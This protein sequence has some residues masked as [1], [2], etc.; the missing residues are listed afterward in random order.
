MIKYSLRAL[1]GLAF[2]LR[3][4]NDIDVYV[5]D[6]KNRNLYEVLINRILNGKARVTS[7]VQLGGRAAVIAACANDQNDSTRR[8]IYLADGDYDLI[9][10][11]AA[12][13]LRYFYRLNVY[14]LEN[15]IITEDAVLEVAFENLIDH[16]KE[17]AKNLIEFQTFI[18]NLKETLL[19]LFA[20]YGVVHRIASAHNMQLHI[21]T[22]A[23]PVFKL[24]VQVAKEPSIE[25]QKVIDRMEEILDTLANDYGLNRVDVETAVKETLNRIE[26]STKDFID[27]ISA[28]SYVLPLLY[29]RLRSRAHYSGSIEQL[30]VHLA[31]HVNLHVDPGFYQAIVETASGM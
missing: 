3:P 14:T 17:D 8:R 6:T 21:Q 26:T 7:V 28:K 13:H 25:K 19:P 4:Y 23:F 18:T 16:S 10:G 27:Y 20:L 30:K 1:R 5:E 31:R 22:S 12:P 11:E 29:Q 24:C 9:N 15:L 2:L